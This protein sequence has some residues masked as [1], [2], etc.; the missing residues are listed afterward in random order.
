M[1]I[2]PQ[3]IDQMFYPLSFKAI[4]ERFNTLQVNIDGSNSESILY[5][6]EIDNISVK[7]FHTTPPPV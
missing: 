7:N 6:T 1:R 3:R 4:A 5:G 2:W